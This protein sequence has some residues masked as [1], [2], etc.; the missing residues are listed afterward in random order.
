MVKKFLD[1]EILSEEFLLK[2]EENDQEILDFFKKHC[3]FK[4][5]YNEKLIQMCHPLLEWLKEDSEEEESG[6]DSEEE[7]EEDN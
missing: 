5:E 4:E 2:W 3:L 7:S 1:S 6:E